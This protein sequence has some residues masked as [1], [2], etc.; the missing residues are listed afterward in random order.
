MPEKDDSQFL[1]TLWQYYDLHGR[2][3]LPW[4]MAEVDGTYDPYKILVSEL[5]LQQTQVARVVPKFAAFLEQFPNTK[6]LAAASLSEVLTAWSGLGYN[7]RAKFLHQAAQRIED[8]CLGIFPTDY[9]ELIKLPGVG[10][11]TAG[12]IMAYAFNQ[13]IVYIETNIRTVYIHHY[14]SDGQAIHD[15]QLRPVIERTLDTDN[16]R[17]FYWA[18]MDY[19]SWLKQQ[20]GNLNKLSVHYTKQSPFAGSLREIRGKVIRLLTARPHSL[21]EL[22]A[23]IM[24]ARLASVL[25]A[26]TVEGLITQSADDEYQLA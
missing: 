23:I 19:G 16:P 13:P 7:R 12:A 14:F 24:D 11:N 22:E 17:A 20:I 4:R 18:L 21:Q 25:A 10:A 1:A 26:L 9:T 8:E 6:Q 2:H 3:E 15:D 5:M